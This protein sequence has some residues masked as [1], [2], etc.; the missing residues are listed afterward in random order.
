MP[1]TVNAQVLEAMV[2]TNETVLSTSAAESQGVTLEASA[3]STALL[4]MN[5]VSTQY[6]ASQIA[7][8]SVVTACAEILKAAT[9]RGVIR[10]EI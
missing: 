10:E 2:A 4:M 3:Y 7:N 6:S 9:S 1:D 5:A 8:A